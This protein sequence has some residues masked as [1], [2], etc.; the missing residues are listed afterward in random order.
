MALALMR[1]SFSKREGSGS[2][3]GAGSVPL[4]NGSGRF[5][6]NSKKTFLPELLVLPVLWHEIYP[7]GLG[8]LLQVDLNELEVLGVAVGPEH[9]LA[10]QVRHVIVVGLEA[11]GWN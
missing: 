5:S 1:C 6:Q 3:S 8:R 2:R 4:T 10:P 9:G 11:Q 7:A